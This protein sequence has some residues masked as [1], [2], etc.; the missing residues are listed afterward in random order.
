MQ[1]VKIIPNE[2][3]GYTATGTTV[4]NHD[5]EHIQ[6]VTSIKMDIQA[7]SMVYAT[8]KL[9]AQFDE[10]NAYLLLDEETLRRS[11]EKL[12]YRLVKDAG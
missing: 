6:G 10:M 9:V 11:A 2:K 3:G 7:G 8:M 12:G 4:L 5:G 1:T